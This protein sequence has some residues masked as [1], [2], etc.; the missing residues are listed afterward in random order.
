M[1]LGQASLREGG[2]RCRA[3]FPALFME[4]QSWSGATVCKTKALTPWTFAQAVIGSAPV[5]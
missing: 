5:F 2:A 1:A 4:Q 3:V